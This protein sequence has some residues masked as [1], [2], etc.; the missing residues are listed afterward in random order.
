MRAFIAC[1]HAGPCTGKDPSASNHGGGDSGT[2]QE[3]AGEVLRLAG[4]VDGN[5]AFTNCHAPHCVGG[6]GSYAYCIWN[7][8]QQTNGTAVSGIASKDL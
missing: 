8:Q 5:N 2:T 4:I 3:Q 7:C 1:D 6:D